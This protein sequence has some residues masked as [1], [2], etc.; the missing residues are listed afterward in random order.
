[1][2]DDKHSGCLVQ[3]AG[4]FATVPEE[5]TSSFIIVCK[6]W[7]RSPP[8]SVELNEKPLCFS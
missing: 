6:L 4:Q 7:V 1:V 2:I 8:V 5:A 3:P